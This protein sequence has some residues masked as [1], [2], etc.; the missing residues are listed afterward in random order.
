MRCL[1]SPDRIVVSVRSM[2]RGEKS[3]PRASAPEGVVSGGRDDVP[4]NINDTVV[5][6]QLRM[7]MGC[8]KPTTTSLDLLCARYQS[9]R[10]L[11]AMRVSEV[12]SCRRSSQS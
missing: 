5:V 11:I 10:E 12:F 8:T 3:I 4:S 6:E 2:R 1:R 9:I 7:R